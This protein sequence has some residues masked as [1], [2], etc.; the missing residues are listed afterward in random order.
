MFIAR[1][2]ISVYT[3]VSEHA[4]IFCFQNNIPVFSPALTDGSL[5]DMIYFHSFKNPGLVLDIVEG[6]VLIIGTEK[7]QHSCFVWSYHVCGLYF[8][9]PR[10][11]QQGGVCQKDRN[12]HPGRRFG[13]T[14]HSQC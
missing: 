11:E 5:G 8:R 1:H 14:S 7:D 10:D 4:D 3:S 6:K 2:S 12:D 9:Y 13:Q